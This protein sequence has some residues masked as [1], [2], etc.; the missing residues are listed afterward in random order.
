V[1]RDDPAGTA[2]HHPRR[3]TPLHETLTHNVMWQIKATLQGLWGRIAILEMAY[4]TRR[5]SSSREEGSQ[6]HPAEAS[7]DGD[8]E[9]G[10]QEAKEGEGSAAAEMQS[11]RT[12]VEVRGEEE[13]MGGVS[14][15]ADDW[16]ESSF[17]ISGGCSVKYY[18]YHDSHCTDSKDGGMILQ[19]FSTL[20][21]VAPVWLE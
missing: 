13:T 11:E 2:M 5:G 7:R 1:P 18:G 16:W 3:T 10:Q 8:A 15:A 4:K 21:A 9:G 14:L 20:R 6:Q 12:E 17:Y 19:P